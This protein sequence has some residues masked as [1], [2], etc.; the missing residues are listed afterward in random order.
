MKKENKYSIEVPHFYCLEYYEG[1]KKMI[2]EMDF[3]E[4]F[5]VL[6]KK[7]ILNWEPPYQNEILSDDEKKRILLN[8]RE[9]LL[10]RT[11]PSNIIMDDEWI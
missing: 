11:I 1:V 5:F 8:I 10:N 9:Y 3:R 2:V 4:S 7:L 6:N